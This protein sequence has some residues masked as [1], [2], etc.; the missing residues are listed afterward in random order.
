MHERQ[1]KDKL[2]KIRQ[3]CE[4][5]LIALEKEIEDLDEQLGRK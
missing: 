2:R 3:N 1:A 5:A 4:K